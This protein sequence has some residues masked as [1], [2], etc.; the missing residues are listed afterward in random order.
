M[1]IPGFTAGH[2]IGSSP[3]R[4]VVP[5]SGTH[6]RGFGIGQLKRLAN[7][8]LQQHFGMYCY[9]DFYCLDRCFWN[10]GGRGDVQIGGYKLAMCLNECCR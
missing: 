5:Q 9:H 10:Q 2:T 1:I 8:S 7:E 3:D 4:V 6:G